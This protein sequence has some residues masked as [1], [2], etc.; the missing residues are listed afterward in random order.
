MVEEFGPLLVEMDGPV[1]VVRLNRPDALNSFD[2]ELHHRFGRFCADLEGDEEVRAVVLTGN[3]RAFSAGGNLDDFELFRVDFDKRRATMRMARRL[4]DEM[5]NVHV[6]VVAAVNGPAVGLGATLM[7]L[8]DIVF[9]SQDTFV[10]DPHVASALVAGDGS[11]VTWPAHTG[12][13]RAKQYLLTG[14]RIP[15][16]VA[17]EMGLA[18]F[19]VPADEVVPQAT[20]FAHR[21]AKLPPQAVQDT[22]ILL[23]Q[24]LRSNA[25]QVLGMGLAA[26]SQSHDT[27]EFAAVPQQVRTR[28]HEKATSAAQPAARITTEGR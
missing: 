7:T 28:A 8:C 4:V 23:N 6:P 13:L 12:L 26:E 27:A 18:N 16:A 3:G 20:A 5:L 9:I 15:A 2:I 17:V 11:A 21:L 22:K 1:C 14:D 19:A 24:I 10:A 25:V